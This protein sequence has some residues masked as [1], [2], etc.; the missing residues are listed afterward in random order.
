MDGPNKRLATIIHSVYPVDQRSHAEQ[1]DPAASSSK[2]L[3]RLA[4]NYPFRIAGE[5][6]PLPYQH[7]LDTLA[8]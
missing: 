2:H 5:P 4:K 1:T 7:K 6:A 8:R 3:C